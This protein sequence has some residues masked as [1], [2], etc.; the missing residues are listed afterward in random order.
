MANEPKP[1]ASPV[2]P[3]GTQWREQPRPGL[4]ESPISAMIRSLTEDPAIR[5][6]QRYAWQRWR[7]GDGSD[8]K[9]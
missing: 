2:F 4:Y 1:P 9:R 6:D 5:E 3:R 8:G 7:S